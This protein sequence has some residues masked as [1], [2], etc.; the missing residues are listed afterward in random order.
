M[1][2]FTTGLKYLLKGSGIS[3]A[4]FIPPVTATNMT[5]GRDE[6]KMSA[7]KLIAAILPQ[8]ENGKSVVTTGKLRLFPWIAFFLPGLAHKILSK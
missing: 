1:H 5:A 6:N 4:E 7:D 8:L 2:N 3:V